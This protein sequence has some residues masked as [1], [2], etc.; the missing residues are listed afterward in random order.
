MPIIANLECKPLERLIGTRKNGAGG[1]QLMLQQLV[2][3][4]SNTSEQPVEQK[5][6]IAH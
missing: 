4:L 6:Q 3:N 5:Q 2:L 1:N